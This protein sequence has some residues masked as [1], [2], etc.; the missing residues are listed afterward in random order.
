L[1]QFVETEY[2]KDLLVKKR[3]RITE[4]YTATLWVMP[5]KC[6]HFIVT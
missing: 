4:Q 5:L 6:S 3:P 1:P 2:K